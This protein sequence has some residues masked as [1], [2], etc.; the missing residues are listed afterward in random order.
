M[1]KIK[2]LWLSLIK[3]Y[4]KK[5]ELEKALL[6][7]HEAKEDKGYDLVREGF[8]IYM[9]R[10]DVSLYIR[11]RI[12]RTR[13]LSVPNPEKIIE[14]LIEEY[15]RVGGSLPNVM[16]LLNFPTTNYFRNNLV[17]RLIEGNE[18]I[19]CAATVAKKGGI[20]KEIIEK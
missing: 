11:E 12:L 18:D 10:A 1:E 4:I 9:Q 19:K 13:A 16:T 14:T 7:S 15:L 3:E 6:Y 5:G 20:K 17:V 2:Q 8:V